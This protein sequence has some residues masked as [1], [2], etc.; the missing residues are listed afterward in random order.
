MLSLVTVIPPD[1]IL[2]NSFYTPAWSRDIE[3][4]RHMCIV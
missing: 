4:G 1:D 3:G 2:D